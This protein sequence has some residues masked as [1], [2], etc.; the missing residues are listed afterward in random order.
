MTNNELAAALGVTPSVTSRYANGKNMPFD[1]RIKEIAA[2]TGVT[3]EKCAAMYLV[4]NIKAQYGEE[5]LS[6]VQTFGLKDVDVAAA[7]HI[8][9]KHKGL[10][11]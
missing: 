4:A 10:G 3:F 5:V 6:L 1:N 8:I 11:E 9:A 7:A 2:I